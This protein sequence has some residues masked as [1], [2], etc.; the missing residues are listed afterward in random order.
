MELS[1]KQTLV[2]DLVINGAN[3]FLTGP[4]GSGKTALIKIIYEK[5]KKDCKNIQLTAMTGVAAIQL[6]SDAKTLHSWAGIGLG[7]QSAIKYIDK[8][9]NSKALMNK[10][11]NVSAL[12]IDEVSM[13]SE[14][15][16]TKLELIARRIRCNEKLFGGIQIILSGD[17][18]QLPPVQQNAKFCFEAEKFNEIFTVKI[19]LDT[20]YR[21]SDAVFLKILQGIR[22]GKITKTHIKILQNRLIDSDQTIKPVILMPKKLSVDE[23]NNNKLN[24][25]TTEHKIFTKKIVE[26]LEMTKDEQQYIKMLSTNEYVQE[27]EFLEKNNVILDTIKLKIG[28]QVMS[29]INIEENDKLI[30]SNGTQGVVKNFVNELP[31]VEFENGISRLVDIHTWKCHA[32]PCCGICQIPLILSWAITIH[33]AQ[34]CTLNHC[35]MNIGD[36]IFEAGQ[37]YVALSRVKNL[38]GI[39]LDSFNPYKIKINTK[40]KDFYNSIT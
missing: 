40:V 17:F 27:L 11:K 34:G 39:Y 15:L 13:L 21:Q 7:D 18:Y 31:F 35:R 32:I 26:D 28:A 4:G 14:D 8:I 20:I 19:V 16:F 6:H 38:E 1:T 36:D 12:I 24:E 9:K 3:V 22:L 37:T 23:I 5:F 33:K 25:L 2:L 30:I 10:W 29:I